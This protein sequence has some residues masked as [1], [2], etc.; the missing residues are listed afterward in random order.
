MSHSLTAASSLPAEGW[1]RRAATLLY[2]ARNL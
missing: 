1:L 2:R